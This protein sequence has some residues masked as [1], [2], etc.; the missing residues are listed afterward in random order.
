[1]M[2]HTILVVEAHEATAAFLAEHLSTDGYKPAVATTPE[3]F[4]SLGEQTQPHVVLLGDLEDRRATI[5][6]LDDVRSRNRPLDPDTLVLVL[7]QSHTS[8]NVLRAFEHGADD[9]IAKPFEYLELRARIAARLRRHHRRTGEVLRVRDLL[10]D[11]RQRLVLLAGHPI[12]LTQREFTLLVHL[13]REP[14]RVFTKAELTEQLWGYPE[15]C[16]TR[17]LDSHACRLRGKLAVNGDRSWVL[18]VWGVGYALTDVRADH[19]RLART[20][21]GSAELGSKA[22]AVEY[23]HAGLGLG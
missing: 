14:E 5:A 11:T 10:I 19:H 16:R 2:P 22:D 18:S 17:T 7:S 3:A 23:V 15:E 20:V 4:Y 13:A 12:A 9:V 21:R 6:L 8:L 1:M